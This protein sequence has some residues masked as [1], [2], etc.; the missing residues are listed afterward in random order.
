MFFPGSYK[1]KPFQDYLDITF[2]FYTIKY[3]SSKVNESIKKRKENT[4]WPF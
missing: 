4:K 2:N 3:V 1:M